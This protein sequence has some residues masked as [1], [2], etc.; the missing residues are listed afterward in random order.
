MVIQMKKKKVT[1]SLYCPRKTST[2]Q[3]T[4]EDFPHLKLVYLILTIGSCCYVNV[5]KIADQ[6]EV[7]VFI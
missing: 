1:L 7:D 5:I 4:Q 2:L 3:P 6:Q